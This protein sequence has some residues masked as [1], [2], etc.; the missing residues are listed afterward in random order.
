MKKGECILVNKQITWG[1]GPDSLDTRL[2]IPTSFDDNF[3]DILLGF[4]R[5]G[6]G[7][8]QRNA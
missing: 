7:G 4:V 2:Q 3:L 8:A 1:N 6:S 5:I